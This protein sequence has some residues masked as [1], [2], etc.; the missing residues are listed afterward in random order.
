MVSHKRPLR[1]ACTLVA[2]AALALAG[3]GDDTVNPA[4]PD[5]GPSKDA[6]VDGE[7]GADGA[8]VA[9]G[10]S[11]DA[12]DAG[13]EAAGDGGIDAAHDASDA[14]SDTGNDA[15]DAE[16]EGGPDAGHD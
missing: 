13:A 1:R 11:A 6:T 3:C 2:A 4:N 10:G 14:T 12:S 8:P 15:N 9:E 5:A 7:A 16:A